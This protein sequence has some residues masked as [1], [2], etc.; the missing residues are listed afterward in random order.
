MESF[1]K[2]GAFIHQVM[3]TLKID[4]KQPDLVWTLYHKILDAMSHTGHKWWR[5]MGGANQLTRYFY[6]AKN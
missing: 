3:V 4:T 1:T 6:I 2:F 5:K